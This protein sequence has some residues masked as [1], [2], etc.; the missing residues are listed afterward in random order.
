MKKIDHVTGTYKIH[1]EDIYGIC[2]NC[3]WILDGALSLNKSKYTDGYSD[4]VWMVQ[5]WHNYLEKKVTQYQKS[6]ITIL[7]EGIEQL[8]QEFSRFV[9][10]EALSKLDRASA[11]IALVRVNHEVLECF[12]LGDVEIN[13]HKKNKEIITLVDS[14]IEQLDNK[15]MTMIYNNTRREQE[16]VLNDYT[17]EELDL[18]RKHRE[19]MNT[20]EGYYVLEHDVNAIK[21]GIYKEFLLEDVKEIL[22]M[23]D[24]FSAIY[25]KYG[26]F[27]LQ[28]LFEKCESDG[29]SSVLNNIRRIETDDPKQKK[30]KRLRLHDD[31]T[32]IYVS[33]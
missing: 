15:V 20:L 21:K 12:V 19:K 24:G 2:D 30:H 23:S 13:I 29:L 4:V 9:S 22:I 16:I 18:L 8:N 1:N 28:Q 3:Y 10:I 33:K 14:K 11:G 31:A 17:Q 5:W 26:A 27:S 6:L 32:A 25:N 7:E